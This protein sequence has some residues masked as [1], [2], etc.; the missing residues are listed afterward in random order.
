MQ[1]WLSVITVVRDDRAGLDRTLGSLRAQRQQDFEWIVVD[2]MSADYSFDVALGAQ[3]GCRVL[4]E[5]K[6]PD[7]IYAA[8]NRATELASGEW[9]WYL[10]AGDF[11][12]SPDAV[13]TMK[14]ATIR[15]TTASLIACHVDVVTEDG[16]LFD[17]ITPAVVTISGRLAPSF[18]HQG[19]LLRRAAILR[20]GGYR[21]DLPLAADGAL[22]KAV[23]ERDGH[24]I[25]E[26]TLVAFVLGGASS[27]RITQTMREINQL[28]SD[29]FSL[30]MIW[31]IALKQALRDWIAPP[32]NRRSLSALRRSYM[33]RRQRIWL[34][35]HLKHSGKPPLWLDR[36]DTAAYSTC[37]PQFTRLREKFQS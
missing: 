23:M 10:N 27:R 7:G 22:V 11:L 21:L 33:R 5:Q 28:V 37:T 16:F 12:V 24:I 30:P 4:A 31:K 25:I 14:A 20:N 34:C 3:V 26:D 1:P 35:Y 9:L 2:G 19:T 8:M 29:A 6:T 18:N 32:L 17:H 36:A 13:S 15:A